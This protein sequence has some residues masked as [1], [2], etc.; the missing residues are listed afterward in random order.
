MA[1]NEHNPFVKNDLLPSW[2]ANAIQKFLSTDAPSF[3]VTKLDATHIQVTAAA[4]EGAAIIAIAGKW[5]WIEATITR[6]HPGGASATW[7]IYVVAAANKIAGGGIDE[8]NYAYE[9][10]ILESGKTPTLEAGVVDIFRKVGSLEWSGTEITRVDQTV[11]ATPTHAHRH[12]TGQPDAIAA[13]DIG[14]ATAAQAVALEAGYQDFGVGGQF[15]DGVFYSSDW[16]VTATIN[17]AT[18]AI[19]SSGTVGFN[20]RV[21]GIRTKTNPLITIS[22]LIPPSLP[23]S[24]QFMSV[25]LQLG[26]LNGFNGV[27]TP[28]VVSGVAKATEAEALAAPAG[29]QGSRLRIKDIIIK[30]T[31]GVYSIVAQR[32]RRPWVNGYYF[33]QGSFGVTSVKTTAPLT[34][35]VAR[36][37]AKSGRTGFRIRAN[38]T[39]ESPTAGDVLTL[40]I[41]LDKGAKSSVRRYAFPTAAAKLTIAYEAV[42]QAPTESHLVELIASMG[43]EGAG[44]EASIGAEFAGEGIVQLEEIPISASNGTS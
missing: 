16:Q 3:Q 36:F 40:A 8:T 6:A 32:D 34:L 4:A 33:L 1:L 31:A 21:A 9:L 44:H 12:A 38:F 25:G 28:S 20:A 2:W 19:G 10:R 37:E 7:D 41:S 30:N 13:A 35:F 39:A 11:N 15:G 27:A 14:A 23:A 24:G 42:I 5:R 22:G 18:A 43:V 29:P 26:A 17:S